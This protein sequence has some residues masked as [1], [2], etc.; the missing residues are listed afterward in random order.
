MLEHIILGERPS[1]YDELSTGWAE[2]G[3]RLTTLAG[4]GGYERLTQFVPCRDQNQRA[5][6]LLPRMSCER[7]QYY[8]WDCIFT[9]HV[10]EFGPSISRFHYPD[11]LMC[12]FHSSVRNI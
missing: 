1:N 12:P 11:S 7:R 10:A 2:R 3:N 5:S 6:C 9:S 8:S 4:G